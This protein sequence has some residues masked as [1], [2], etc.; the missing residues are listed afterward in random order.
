M[1]TYKI[2]RLY[3]QKRDMTISQLKDLYQPEDLYFPAENYAVIQYHEEGLTW[4]E[5]FTKMAMLHVSQAMFTFSYIRELIT[6]FGLER[7]PFLLE[8][9]EEIE[10]DSQLLIDGYSQRIA[11]ETNE[12]LRKADL[13][14]LLSELHY[15]AYEKNIDIKSIQIQ[16][17]EDIAIVY[18]NGIVKTTSI[19][20]LDKVLS[21]S[22]KD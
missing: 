10:V 18:N 21:I 16:T 17:D 11:T 8:F 4:K 13:Q 1:K 20:F 15:L 5:I 14:H 22:F 6:H 19:E 2:Y 7:Y 9:T 12:P 3:E